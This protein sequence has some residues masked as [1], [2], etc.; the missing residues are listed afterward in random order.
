MD[1]GQLG[2][3]PPDRLD[4]LDAVASAF[5][6]ARRQGQSER[7]EEQVGRLEAI[8][9]DGEVMDRPGGTQLPV[10]CAGLAFCVDAGADDSGPVVA[11]QREEAIE[12]SAGG[13]PILEVHRVEDRTSA[14]PLEC[15]L[16]DGCFGGVDDEGDGRL[17]G[18]ALGHLCH[19]ADSVGAGVVDA[20]IEE[21]GALAG[22]V[23]GHSDRRLP[24]TCEH[25]VPEA[26]RAVRVRPFP[27]DKERELLFERH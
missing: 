24:V 7:V 5:F 16:G 27:D 25:R 4:R 26:L 18:E 3:D 10:G 11:G 19:V 22:L 23:A 21:M 12:A 6:H 15:R 1:T 17:G 14:D 8:A 20:N 9:P 13:V 2:L